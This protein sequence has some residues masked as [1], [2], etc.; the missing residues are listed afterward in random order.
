MDLGDVLLLLGVVTLL[1]M[2]TVVATTALAVRGVRRRYRRLRARMSMRGVGTTSRP[3]LP[4]V[5]AAAAATVGSAAWWA[6][7]RDRQRMWRAVSGAQNAV[8]VAQ[9]AGAPVGDLPALCRQ[10]SSAAAGVDAV[11]RAGAGD[12]SWRRDASAEQVEQAALDVQRAAVQSIT[13]HTAGDTQPMLTAVRQEVVALSA[14]V[15]AASAAT[16]P[17]L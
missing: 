12:R 14:G 4:A 9:E 5:R 11:L 16:R 8:A 2:V 17:V 1:L 3:D 10:L 6:S 15:R 7:Q 13:M